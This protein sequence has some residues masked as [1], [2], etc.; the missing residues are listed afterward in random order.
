MVGFG[1]LV[2]KSDLFH[3]NYGL[4][5]AKTLNCWFYVEKMHLIIY[6]YSEYYKEPK[7]TAKMYFEKSE[8]IC[9]PQSWFMSKFFLKPPGVPHFQEQVN[10]K[11]RTRVFTI[12]SA[13][14]DIMKMGFLPYIQEK[15][16]LFAFF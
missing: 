1:I 14:K 8:L 7:I 10:K 6:S 4:K 2:A 5:E 15:Q 16:T 11:I 13:Y 9:I 3:F 12:H